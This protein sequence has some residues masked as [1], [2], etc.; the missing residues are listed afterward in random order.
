[1]AENPERSYTYPNESDDPDRRD[2]LRNKLGIRSNGELRRAEYELT[3]FRQAEL[4]EGGGPKGN[5]D[6]AHLKAIHGFI[7]QD[8]YE[9]AGHTRNERPMVDGAQ[10]EPIGN[11]S[12]GGTTFLHGSRIEMGLKE[13]L[14]PIQ[15]PEVLR[16]S[17]SAEFAERA[18]TVLSELNYVHAFREGNGR[19]QE[20]FIAALGRE[21]GHEVAF[22]VITKPRMIEAS[23]E[24]TNDPS[25]RA[26]VHLMED[27]TDPGRR[28]VI[29]STFEDLRARGEDPMEH[30]VRTAAPGEV[31]TGAVLGSDD[32]TVSLVTD[33][34]IVAADRHD[35]P[36]ELPGDDSDITFQARSDYSRHSRLEPSRSGDSSNSP[37]RSAEQPDRGTSSSGG[38]SGTI[39]TRSAREDDYER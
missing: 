16:G 28:E 18:G 8:V 4:F 27:A 26:M 36:A 29:R 14:K 17:T 1:M 9:W 35:L 37:A 33:R 34:G 32:Q 22:S 3:R 12:K 13:A 2:V 21:Y 6:A 31:V 15:D 38:G 20:S 19:A 10:V 23:I 5:F 39:K 11:L 30:N 7:F 25:S 24:S